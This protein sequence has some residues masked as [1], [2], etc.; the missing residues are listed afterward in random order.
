[1]YSSQSILH[2]NCQHN[3]MRSEIT[4]EQATVFLNLSN[5]KLREPGVINSC[6][7]NRRRRKNEVIQRLIVL[8]S[9]KTL[10]SFWRHCKKWLVLPKQKQIYMLKLG[11][12]LRNLPNT[13]VQNFEDSNFYPLTE[14]DEDILLKSKEDR[15]AGPL[16]VY[17]R[18]AVFDFF[19]KN[20]QVYPN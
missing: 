5:Q 18:R 12:T 11:F 14:G 7:E 19:F 10:F 3:E 13:C 8:V 6:K 1:M 17:T 9:K 2:G 15:L 16:T 4:A 20:R